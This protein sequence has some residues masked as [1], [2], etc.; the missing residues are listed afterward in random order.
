MRYLTVPNWKKHQHRDLAD[1]GN[2][3]WFKLES[4]IFDDPAVAALSANAF[5]A[6]IRALTLAARTGNKLP[7]NASW[8]RAQ[9]GRSWRPLC[10]QLVDAK[11]LD[12]QVPEP[13]RKCSTGAAVVQHSRSTRSRLA[14]TS[15]EM[16]KESLQTAALRRGSGAPLP[17]LE[18]KRREQTVE[19]TSTEDVA[20]DW[21]GEPASPL[22]AL[23][24]VDPKKHW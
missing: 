15:P 16:P 12:G 6:Y 13:A 24:A 23:R 5:C 20:G 14:E 7:A 17:S 11:L 18:E 2:M 1:K 10:A 22:R 8:L 4:G 21:N 9:F 3:P 19:V